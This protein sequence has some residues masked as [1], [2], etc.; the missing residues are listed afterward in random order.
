MLLVAF[1]F[2]GV[3]LPSPM[4]P[5]E[6]VESD[7]EASRVISGG[8][9]ERLGEDVLTG[10]PKVPW[11][12]ALVVEPE[13]KLPNALVLEG[14][15][16]ALVVVDLNAV[17]DVPPNA[18]NPEANF[19]EPNAELALAPVALDCPKAPNEDCPKAG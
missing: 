12:N 9:G 3:A 5:S 13:L 2:D 19:G 6:G 11:P 10:A 18:P 4:L 8:G 14:D 17:E 16:N 7:I 15:P 1:G